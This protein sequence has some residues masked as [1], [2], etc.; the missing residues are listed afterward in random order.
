MGR[1]TLPLNTDTS[2]RYELFSDYI[3]E[4]QKVK[5]LPLL[6]E[7]QLNESYKSYI[8]SH[9]SKWM[10]IY[11]D[12]DNKTVIGFLII[13]Y[14]PNCH[15]DADFY[16]EE[17]YITPSYRRKKYMSSVVSQFV[18]ANNGTYCLFIL[19][20]N[21]IVTEFWLK[22]FTKLGYSLCE[23]R[24]VGAGDPYCNQYGFR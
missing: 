10:D 22:T 13:G 3:N 21:L 20:N 24:D 5:G 12:E 11:T 14:P 2:K 15:P 19:K 16:V 23:L 17:A 9:N 8:S 7:V 1:T 18:K 6:S 4:L